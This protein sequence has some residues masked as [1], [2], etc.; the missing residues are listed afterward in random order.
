[1]AVLSFFEDYLGKVYIVILCKIII[2]M[3]KPNHCSNLL[4][5][6]LA[7][8]FLISMFSGIANTLKNNNAKFISQ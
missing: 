6:V 8:L 3:K 4:I 2:P 7:G 1:M 5:I